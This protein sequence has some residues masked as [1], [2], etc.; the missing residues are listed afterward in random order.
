MGRGR[1][2]IGARRIVVK[3]GSGLITAPGEGPVAPRISALAADLAALVKDRRE[4]A[5][6]SSGAIAT[7][8]AR[9]GLPARPR[10]I[11]GEAGGRRRRAIGADVAVRAGLQAPRHPGRPGAA[12]AGGH[13]RSL[14][15][16]QRAQHAP[17]APRLRRLAH[18][19]RERHGGRGRDQG[20][21]QRQSRRARRAPDRRRPPGPAHRRGRALHGRPAARSHRPA[22]R[23]GGGHHRG[24]PA[25]RLRH[26]GPRV[27]RAG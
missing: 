20:R 2:L 7:G 4:V 14:A 12:H 26:G 8:M 19:Q 3:V 6:V 10:S 23:D 25:A 15:L 18:H 27:R 22:P 17:R 5:L 13:Q 1:A 11:P 16:P 9:L 21:R 24:H